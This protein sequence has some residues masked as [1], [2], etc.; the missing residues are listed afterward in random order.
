LRRRRRRGEKMVSDIGDRARVRRLKYWIA[1]LTLVPCVVLAGAGF[2]RASAGYVLG[3]SLVFLNLMGTEKAVL[4]FVDGSGGGRFLGLALYLVKLALTAAVIAAVL[5]TEV[6]SP[7]ALMLGV[8]T[9][10]MAL[11]F[12]ILIFPRNIRNNENMEEP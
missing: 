9:L 12:D 7:F 6:V 2:A 4:A 3:G 8:T 1:G 5:L 10:L 11:V